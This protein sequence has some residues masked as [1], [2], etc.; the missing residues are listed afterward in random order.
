MTQAITVPTLT[1]EQVATQFTHWRRTRTKRGRTPQ[2]LIDQAVALRTH[3]PVSQIIQTLGLNHADY[4][5]HC[6]RAGTGSQTELIAAATFVPVS[7][8]EPAWTQSS[9][10]SLTLSHPD[11]RCLQVQGVT[12]PALQSLVQSFWGD[13]SCCN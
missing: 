6:H 1:L 9:A 10:M 12:E 2:D 11:G 4:K 13:V 8:S 7:T 3:Y 5:K